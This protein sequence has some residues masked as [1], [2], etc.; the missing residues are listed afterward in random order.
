MLFRKTVAVV[1]VAA[2][3]FLGNA[4]AFS[5][6]AQETPAAAGVSPAAADSSANMNGGGMQQYDCPS[7]EEQVAYILGSPDFDT[8]RKQGLIEKLIV[9]GDI[10]TSVVSQKLS[11]ASEA[12]ALLSDGYPSLED[13]VVA[14]VRDES[15]EADSRE[16]IL[17][18]V[19]GR[20]SA[21]ARA[22]LNAAQCVQCILNV[23]YFRQE[24][25]YYCAPATTKQTL[26]YINGTSLSQSQYAP[27]VGSGSGIDYGGVGTK[28]INYINENQNRNTYVYKHKTTNEVSVTNMRYFIDWCLRTANCPVVF[29]IWEVKKE[30]WEYAVPKGHFLNISGQ[31]SNGYFQMTDPFIE[32]KK[33]NSSGKYSY[34]EASVYRVFN[35]FG[36]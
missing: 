27:H 28:L 24:N 26:H 16:D 17:D 12:V 35:C 5:A 10:D 7:M 23:P 4:A 3:V 11:S 33:P 18:M 15:V 13:Q 36:Y 32:Y 22:V 6:T 1:S 31:Y 21:N 9:L 34:S 19:S 29:N 14:F 2:A 8:Q 25:G 30:D 20:M